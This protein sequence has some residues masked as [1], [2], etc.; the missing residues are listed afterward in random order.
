MKKRYFIVLA[1]GCNCLAPT[2][3]YYFF[4]GIG[5]LGWVNKRGITESSSA[6]IG[7]ME[8]ALKTGQ[9]REI[10]EPELVLL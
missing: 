7:I 3:K 1:Y 9:A 6:S 2:A 10:F 5:R 4:D 8:E